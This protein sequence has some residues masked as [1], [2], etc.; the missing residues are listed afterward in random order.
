MN[1][2]RRRVREGPDSQSRRDR[3]PGRPHAE[4]D[5]HPLGRCL[6]RN[7]PRRAA[8]ARGRRGLPDRPRRARREL[9]EHRQDHRY[10]EG[11]RGRGDP[12][13]L[14]L[15]RRE[16]RLRPRLRRGRDRLHRTAAGG[17]RRDGLEDAGARDHGR[18]RGADRAR[19]HR[20]GQGRRRGSPAGRGSRLP[21]RLQ[22]RWRR[23][24]QGVPRGDDPGRPAGGL[25]GRRPRG[26]EVLL[27]RPR[28]RRALPRGP[29][30]RRGPGAGRRARQRDSR[31]RARLLGPAP[32][33]EGDRG[34][35]GPPGRRR[36][37]GADWQ[38]RHRRGRRGRLPLGGHGRG[39]AG[40]RRVLLPRDEHAG[41]GRALRDRDG[42][43]HRHRPRAGVGCRRRGAVG[44][45]G[46]RAAARPRDRVPDQRRGG[47]QEIR[48]GSGCDHDLSRARGTGR[49]GRFRR[50]GRL[51]GDADVRPDGRQADRL[52][53]RPRAR[54]PAHAARP[55]RV[56]GRRP[57][58]ADPLS[59]GPARDRAMGKRRDLS[60]PDGGSR[61][62]QDDGAG[63]GW[64][65]RR[66][67]RR[68]RAGQP[69]LQGRGLG[70]ALRGQGDR[71][72]RGRWRCSGWGRQAP[73]QTRAQ[74]WGRRGGLQRVVA[75]AVA[76]H[77]AQ[78]RRRAGG[79]GIRGR[80]DLRDRGDEDG[81]RDSGP[82]R[83]QGGGAERRRGRRR[84]P[85]ATSSR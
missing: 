34:G 57:D 11:G 4:G 81:E 60:R 77:R 54:N 68:R 10:G 45:P 13:G 20:A 66:G 61:V 73:A 1:R 5:G 80:P 8:R 64:P 49:S 63:G 47:A 67:A 40:R 78:S 69:R 35:T 56:R 70:Q 44:C 15:P 30:P 19:R 43:R 50:R 59:Q 6:L 62:A 28:L 52:G 53:R 38:D 21:G 79:R 83:R 76:G 12:P 58:H 24:R 25:R 29:P 3:D 85:A 42:Q 72:G 82:P 75:L 9:P 26:R 51:R 74:G 16:R 39:P 65:S 55:R 27:R 41:A 7:R 33:P 22:G 31:R 14:R 46:G 84:L 48:P 18:G 36:D 23:W 37:A 71:R 2:L 32:P 17:D